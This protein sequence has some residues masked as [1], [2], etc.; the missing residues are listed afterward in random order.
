[1][2]VKK[3]LAVAVLSL[4]VGA[5]AAATSLRQKAQREEEMARHQAEWGR[6]PLRKVFCQGPPPD[7]E[8]TR[9]N[10]RR[11]IQLATSKVKRLWT[12][13]GKESP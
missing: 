1:M 12:G 9:Y 7:E 13:T 8:T 11:F 6:A 4:L 10:Q 2:S 5:G 3:N